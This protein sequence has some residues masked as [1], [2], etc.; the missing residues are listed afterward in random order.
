MKFECPNCSSLV[1]PVDFKVQGSVAGW[2]CKECGASVSMGAVST[3]KPVKDVSNEETPGDSNETA[4]AAGDG[5]E[6]KQAEIF[7]VTT[8]CP[9]CGADAK[10]RYDCTRCGLVFSKWNPLKVEELSD[11]RLDPL[12][13]EVVADFENAGVHEKFVDTSLRLNRLD[14]AAAKYRGYGVSNPTE[15]ERTR[16][17]LERVSSVAQFQVLRVEEG[18]PREKKKSASPRKKKLMWGI[19]LLLLL[20]LL[21]IAFLWNP[22]PRNPGGR[23]SDFKPGSQPV[24]LKKTLDGG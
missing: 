3:D 13:E 14:F 23:D 5:T 12:W 24:N 9:K 19:A 20:A 2:T 18:R 22:K 11:E 16:E 21:Y 4:E 15:K 10:D 6:T 17:L 1:E 7:D 8:S